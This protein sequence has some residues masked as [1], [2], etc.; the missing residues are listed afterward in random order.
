[1][2]NNYKEGECVI[3]ILKQVQPQSDEFVVHCYISL[4]RKNIHKQIV[5][6]FSERCSSESLVKDE[7]FSESME[8]TTKAL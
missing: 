1:L 4:I 5:Q 3:N 2:V 7:A 8:G 6:V